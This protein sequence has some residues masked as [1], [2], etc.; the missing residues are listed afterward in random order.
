MASALSLPSTAGLRPAALIRCQAVG[1]ADAAHVWPVLADAFREYGLPRVLRSYN[2][3]VLYVTQDYKEAMALGDQVGVLFEGLL[4]VDGVGA[5]RLA[6][7]H[8]A[9][10]FAVDRKQL[11]LRHQ[12]RVAAGC[13]DHA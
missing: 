11:G 9:T 6:R 13:I 8:V 4:L 1:R 10:G 5:R 7:A 12:T 2:A 3:T